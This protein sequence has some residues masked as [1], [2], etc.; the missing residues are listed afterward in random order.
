MRA[1]EALFLIAVIVL[2]GWGAVTATRSV[3]GG[4]RRRRLA[5]SPWRLSER[6]D[7]EQ[8]VIYAERPDE[9]PL[10]VAAVAF[11]AHDFGSRVEEARA[12]GAEKVAAL[13]SGRR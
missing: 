7:G 3:A 1:V 8:L 10:L 5:H 2:I 9:Q 13:N 4:A 12:E 6:S 11:A